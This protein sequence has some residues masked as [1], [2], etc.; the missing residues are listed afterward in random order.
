[1]LCTLVNA[2]GAVITGKTED[3][4]IL[5]KLSTLIL[6]GGAGLILVNWWRF[7]PSTWPPI[8]DVITGGMIIFLA[9]EGFELIANTAADIDSQR[10]LSRAFYSSVITVIIVYI[11]IAIVTVALCHTVLWLMLGTML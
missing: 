3:V 1:M 9:Y 6:V 7:T 2:L 8:I 5:F 11:V 10:S 4:L